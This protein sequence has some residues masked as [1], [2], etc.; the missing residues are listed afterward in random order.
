MTHSHDEHDDHDGHDHAHDDMDE[1]IEACLQSHVVCTMTAQYGLAQGGDRAAVNHVGLLLD[2]AQICQV[3]ADFMIRGSPYHTAT[4][5]ACAEICRAC[6]E[7]C[8][9]FPD[10][11]HMAQCAEVCA[12][13]AESCERMSDDGMGDMD[14]EMDDEEQDAGTSAT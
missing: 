13:C 8:R 5:A 9:A 11:E 12:T 4:C 2:C 7:A 14:G 3:S 10:D 1:C 6:E